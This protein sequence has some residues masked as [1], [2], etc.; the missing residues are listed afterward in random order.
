MFNQSKEKDGY[1]M[2][3]LANMASGGMAGAS[4]L[5][6]VYSLDYARTRLA[7]DA[8]VRSFSDLTPGGA[9]VVCAACPGWS[10]AFVLFFGAPWLW[11]PP[12]HLHRFHPAVARAT[13][14]ATIGG[15]QPFCACVQNPE[16][17]S[18]LFCNVPRCAS[19]VVQEGRRRA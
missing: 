11:I 4:S 18:G 1:M 13:G 12:P 6:F 5:L 2:W 14:E 16:P 10:L 19:A 15:L 3:F 9:C 8:K 7:N 17:T